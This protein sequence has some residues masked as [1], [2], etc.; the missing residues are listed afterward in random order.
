MPRQYWL[1]FGVISLAGCHDSTAPSNATQLKAPDASRAATRTGSTIFGNSA[2][3][4][5]ELNGTLT[6]THERDNVDESE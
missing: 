5:H 4:S 2:I 1:I 3:G 6:V